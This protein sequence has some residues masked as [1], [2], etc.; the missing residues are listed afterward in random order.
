MTSLYD[1]SVPV[2]I[3]YLNNF[4][5]ILDKAQ[6]FADEKGLKHEE[7]LEFRLVSDMRG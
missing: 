4:S 6:K 2:L 5:A 3:K 7:F 1:Q